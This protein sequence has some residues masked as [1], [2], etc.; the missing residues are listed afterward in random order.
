MEMFGFFMCNSL[1]LNKKQG[2]GTM[3]AESLL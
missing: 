3:L 2:I 1:S